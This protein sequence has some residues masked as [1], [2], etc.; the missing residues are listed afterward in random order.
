[1]KKGL[2]NQPFIT[3][4]GIYMY[5]E[6]SKIKGNNV[7][8]FIFPDE[9][10]YNDGI[11]EFKTAFEKVKNVSEDE[12][13]FFPLFDVIEKRKTKDGENVVSFLY[14][15]ELSIFCNLIFQSLVISN[16]ND[17]EFNNVLNEVVKANNI[18]ES[19]VNYI[20]LL[21]EQ[22]N[23]IE[24]NYDEPEETDDTEDDNKEDNESGIEILNKSSNSSVS[25][26]Q[27]LLK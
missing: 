14:I 19:Q 11:K 7:M 1:M 9:E 2:F 20:K 10:D 12:M 13:D 3:K 4:G 5:F 22:C 6:E 17:E 26:M 27:D 16:I 18:I 21:E 24:E 25:S 15:D 8:L 23:L